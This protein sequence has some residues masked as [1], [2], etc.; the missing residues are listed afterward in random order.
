M[1]GHSVSDPG[2]VEE[3]GAEQGL[4]FLPVETEIETK[5]ITIQSH[6]QSFLGPAIRGYEIHMGRTTHIKGARPFLT[7]TDG[8]T[9]GAVVGRSLG[10]Y[11]HGLLKTR[12]SRQRF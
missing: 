11:F 1:L 9:D 7:K 4:D 3:G 5:K 6:G 10:T 12:I 2:N 8:T